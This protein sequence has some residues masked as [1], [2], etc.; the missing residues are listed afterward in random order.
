MTPLVEKLIFLEQE[1]SQALL[2]QGKQEQ[3]PWAR[4]HFCPTLLPEGT[5][6]F[7]S[8]VISK[9][10]MGQNCCFGD[11]R[12]SKCGTSVPQ[13]RHEVMSVKHCCARACVRRV[14]LEVRAGTPCTHTQAHTQRHTHT[15]SLACIVANVIKP[16]PAV[17]H[18]FTS[19]HSLPHA[20]LF[21][22]SEPLLVGLYSFP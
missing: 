21:L 18:C 16:A 5:F 4:H 3:P 8:D 10:S 9:I 12:S 19:V 1:A 2:K 20:L 22:K 11:H 14:V 7:L 13:T 17:S 6:L 15:Q